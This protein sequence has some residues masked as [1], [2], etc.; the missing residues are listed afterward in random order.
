MLN[1]ARF[2][3]GEEA[4]EQ[5][6]WL[7][8]FWSW[9]HHLLEGVHDYIQFMFPLTEPSLFNS[10]APTLDAAAL[11]QFRGDP[12]IQRNLLRSLEVMLDF[13]G[14]ELNKNQLQIL[15][16]AHFAQRAPE[17]LFPNDHNHLRITRILKCL[18][19]SG[20]EGQ[21]RAFHRALTATVR[22]DQVTA[23]TLRFWASAIN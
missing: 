23:E 7:R 14:F 6:R 4:D 16:A 10:R 2:Y 9:S 22:P 18:M 1:L 17:W 13:Y 12:L 3:R 15:P 21:A 11:A 5:G 20:L 8:D 19:L